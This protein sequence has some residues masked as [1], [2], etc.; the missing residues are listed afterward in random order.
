MERDLPKAAPMGT[1]YPKDFVRVDGLPLKYIS[2]VKL[3]QD[4]LDPSMHVIH[5]T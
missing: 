2:L 4:F 1:I 3:R 5:D